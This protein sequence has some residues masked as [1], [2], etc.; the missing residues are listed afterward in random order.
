ME[1]SERPC[2]LSHAGQTCKRRSSSPLFASPSPSAPLRSPRL[3]S[4]TPA[5]ACLASL[6]PS[7]GFPESFQKGCTPP[8]T[9]FLLS[10]PPS[11]SPAKQTLSSDQ[12][13]VASN[14]QS[15]NQSIS[16]SQLPTTA[17]MQLSHAVLA[18]IFA[19]V[20]FSQTGSSKCTSWRFVSQLVAFLSPS[21]SLRP[22]RAITDANLFQSMA[23]LLRSPHVLKPAS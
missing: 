15:I 7:L 14:S 11:L 18:S 20:A 13:S 6:A 21:F 9:P 10:S 22:A 16:I 2:L 17:N 3:A 1:W 8:G 12:L 5:S 23:M 19:T 4:S